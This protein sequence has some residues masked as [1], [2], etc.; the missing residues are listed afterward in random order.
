MGQAGFFG[1]VQGIHIGAQPMIVIF[2]PCDSC[3]NAGHA[4]PVF[5]RNAPFSQFFFDQVV[6]KVS[7]YI[8]CGFSCSAW[9]HC[10]ASFQFRKAVDDRH[11]IFPFIL[12]MDCLWHFAVS[13]WPLI[14]QTRQRV[15]SVFNMTKLAE[16]SV[17]RMKE[18]DISG[19]LGLLQRTAK[20]VG[21]DLHQDRFVNC[22]C[23]R[24]SSADVLAR[25]RQGRRGPIN[26]FRTFIEQ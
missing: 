2:L 20:A 6:C 12:R 16:L 8:V 22:P 5:E 13:A 17:T 4:K 21:I 25:Y 9:R 15:L 23:A 7:S 26:G 3:G 11:K 24:Y 1:D 18:F 10:A 14:P 19:C